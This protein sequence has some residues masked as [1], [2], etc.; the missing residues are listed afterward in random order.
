MIQDEDPYEGS[1]C[2]Y[3]PLIQPLF[4]VHVTEAT[5]TKIAARVGVIRGVLVFRR[6]TEQGS[7]T[8]L[9]VGAD[10]RRNKI[11]RSS[12]VLQALSSLKT[13]SDWLL[14]AI[15]IVWTGETHLSSPQ[16]EEH[17]A[18]RQLLLTIGDQHQ[19]VMH[20]VRA[21]HEALHLRGDALQALHLR[22]EL[23]PGDHIARELHATRAPVQAADQAL[24]PRRGTLHGMIHLW[25]M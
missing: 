7:E 23:Q 10:I 22:H 25:V 1:R 20:L 24:A 9:R 5:A 19:L 12:I 2:A 21:A 8:A 15:C 18:R 16:A 4:G 17:V 11:N 13:D 3:L 6:A 14:N